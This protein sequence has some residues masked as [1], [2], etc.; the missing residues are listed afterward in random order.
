MSSPDAPIPARRT[1]LRL[2]LAGGAT[3]ALAGCFQPMYAEKTVTPA[4]QPLVE[5]MRQVEIVKIE[6]KLGNDLRN[7]LIFELTGGAGNPVG[8]PYKMFITVV[9]NSASSIV[10]TTSGLPQNRIIHVTANWRVVR[11]GEET[12]PPVLQGKS[13]GSA[14]IDVSEQ[15][16]ANWR[17][18]RDAESRAARMVVEQIRAQLAAYF[19]NPPAPPA[20][21]AAP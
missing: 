1:L 14:S 4:G 10:D 13:S 3:L 16:F 11:A 9:T 21:P 5:M 7:D 15:R 18:T 19:I 12:K 8:A 2:A 17:A 6:G 20:A